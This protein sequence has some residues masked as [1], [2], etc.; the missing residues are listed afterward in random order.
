MLHLEANS[1][2]LLLVD[3]CATGPVWMSTTKKASVILNS[4]RQ[5]P[6]VVLD[7]GLITQKLQLHCFWTIK[8]WLLV[9][10][11]QQLPYKLCLVN[12]FKEQL[13]YLALHSKVYSKFGVA[14]VA[15]FLKDSSCPFSPTKVCI[16]NPTPPGAEN[17]C[18][19]LRTKTAEKAIA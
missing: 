3:F 15:K 7:T 9:H 18:N 19:G 16:V 6:F 5:F 13:F 12:I 10:P 11:L 14:G 2:M 4:F 1:V 17:L 8:M